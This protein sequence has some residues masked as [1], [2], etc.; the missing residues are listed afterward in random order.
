MDSP[1]E[2]LQPGEE[3]K[4]TRLP[5]LDVDGFMEEEGRQLFAR[6]EEKK[7]SRSQNLTDYAGPNI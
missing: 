6:A 2:D 7:R 5:V 1:N 4:E 3:K